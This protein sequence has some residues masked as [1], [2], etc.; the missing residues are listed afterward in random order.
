MATKGDLALWKAL[1]GAVKAKQF[2]APNGERE[3]REKKDGRREERGARAGALTG[4][5]RPASPSVTE[6]A[7]PG[8]PRGV[9]GPGLSER[10]PA[11]SAPSSLLCFRF[12]TTRARL[13]LLLLLN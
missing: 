10:K 12:K 2:V 13:S 3:R 5:L 11:L 6:P 1:G 9:F 8:L 7:A 4:L